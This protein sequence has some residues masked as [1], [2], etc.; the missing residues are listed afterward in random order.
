MPMES[1]FL[2]YPS[3]NPGLPLEKKSSKTI[4]AVLA[5]WIDVDGELAEPRERLAFVSWRL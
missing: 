1:A 4:M 5:K 2:P 3:A